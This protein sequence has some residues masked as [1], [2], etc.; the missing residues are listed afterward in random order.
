MPG[1]P[2]LVAEASY[3][4]AWDQARTVGDVLFRRTRL[5]LLAAPALLAPGAEGPIRVAQAMGAELGWDE[6]RVALELERFAE[7]AR[8]EYLAPETAR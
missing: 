8:T 1:H 5:G 6:P 3:A 4:A 2:D 7:E